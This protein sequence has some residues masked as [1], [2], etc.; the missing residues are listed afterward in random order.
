MSPSLP[1]QESGASLERGGGRELEA[2]KELAQ[3]RR[4]L[5]LEPRD[6][7]SASRPKDIRHLGLCGRGGSSRDHVC[8]K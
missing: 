8:D 7:Q 4:A 6:I 3:I 1:L 5:S 2:V